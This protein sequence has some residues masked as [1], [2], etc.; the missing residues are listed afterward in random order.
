MSENASKFDIAELVGNPILVKSVHSRLRSKHILSWGLIA[1]TITAFISAVIYLTSVENGA[2]PQEAAKFMIVPIIFIQGIV[3]ML[4]GTG[5]VASQLSIEREKGLLDYQ[6]MTPM[7]PTAKILGYL[8]GLPIREYFIFALTLPFLG[9]AIVVG[10]ISPIKMAH[11]YLVFFSSIWLYHMTGMVAGMASS[12]PRQAAMSTQGLVVLLYLV[13]PMLSRFGLTFFEYLTVRPTFFAMVS[14]ELQSANPALRAAAQQQ[15]TGLN[16]RGDIPFFN[17]ELHSTIFTLMVQFFLLTFMYR[18][19]HRKWRD[20]FSHPFSK[21]NA[22]AFYAGVLFLIVGSLWPVLGDKA[23]SEQMMQV[24]GGAGGMPPAW[25][26]FV[27]LLVLL[28][29]CGVACLI[30]ISLITPNRHTQMRELRRARKLGLT[31][32]PFNSDGASSLP[33]V[34]GIT[35]LTVGAYLLLLHH[36][37]ASGW[38]LDRMSGIFDQLAPVLYLAFTALFIQGMRERYSARAFVVSTFLLWMLPA[39]T[40]IIMFV[41]FRA[42]TPGCYVGVLCPPVGLWLSL[43]NFIESSDQLQNAASQFSPPDVGPHL[44]IMTAVGIGT[45]ATLALVFQV[46]LRQWQAARR[47]AELGATPP[48]DAELSEA[49]T[50]E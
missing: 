14:S 38:Y 32:V 39:F 42:W 29:V 8:F 13:L 30:M 27:V 43:A 46:R 20:E 18:V 16:Q 49:S 3:L 1:F 6:R 50:G 10:G 5:A 31:R 35:L 36:A 41:A 7:S 22:M 44:R 37:D 24:F 19:V 45:Y 28:L 9:F 40:M 25:F 34:L 12:K 4:L 33:V 21:F 2:T 17:F 26:L 23:L 15:I 47:S 11:F 48:I